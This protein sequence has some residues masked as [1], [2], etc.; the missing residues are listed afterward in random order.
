MLRLGAGATG[1]AAAWGP[2]LAVGLVVADAAAA[3]PGPPWALLAAFGLLAAAWRGAP[4]RVLVP[5]AG[6]LLL[7]AGARLHVHVEARDWVARSQRRIDDRLSRIEARQRA[8]VGEL[9]ALAGSIAAHP[10]AERALAGDEAALATVFRD[11]ETTREATAERPALALHAL[12]PLTTVAWAGR[13]GDPAVFEG[14]VGGGADVF[15][16]EGSVSTTLVATVPA[17]GAEGRPRGFATASLPVQ[18]RRNIGNQFLRDFDLLTASTGRVE[19]RYVDAREQGGAPPPFPPLDPALVAREGTLHAPDGAVLAAVRV[20]APSLPEVRR[21]VRARY[22]RIL[23]L[24]VALTL[25]LW[26]VEARREQATSLPR[27]AGVVSTL[28][29]VLLALGTPLLP[30]DSPLVSPDVYA[31]TALGPLLR[32]PLDLFLTAAWAAV[33]G[34]AVLE[35]ATRHPRRSSLAGF[36]VAAPVAVAL[37]GGVLV[38]L[39]DGVANSSLELEVVPLWPRSLPHL[40][41][42]AGLLVM[43]AAGLFL[44]AAAL[45]LAGPFPPSPVATAG[46]LGALA[47][48]MAG[49]ERLWPRG[50][51]D[52]PLLPALAL[53]LAA[54]GIAATAARWRGG[55]ER[56][57][58]GAHAALAAAAVTALALALYPSL[59]HFAEAFTRAQ[60]ETDHAPEVLR[61]PLWRDYVLTD[62]MRRIDSLRVL[63]EP[64]PG[65]R[66]AGVE[67]LAFAVWSATDLAAYGFS[68]AVEVQ[69]ASGTVISRFALNLPSITGGSDALPGSD[70]WE[71]SRETGRLASEQF[72]MLHARRALSYHGDLHGAIHLY[73]K[74]DF[75]NLPFVRAR[76]PYSVLF[77]TASR[78]AARERPVALVSYHDSREVAFTTVDRPPAL[79]PALAAGLRSGGRGRWTTLE[80]DNRWH[81]AYVFAGP[82]SIHV[83][84]YPLLTPS[85]YA[86]DLVEAAAGFA[87]LALLG[88]VLVVAVRSV[89]GRD[90]LSVRSL[91]ATVRHRFALRLFVAFILLAFVPVA[92][93]QVLVRNFLEDRLRRE[94]EAQALERA[95]IA[96]KGVEDYA[97]FQ[98]E[99]SSAGAPV[100]DEALVWLASVI[101]NDLDVF[102]RGRLLA[103]SKR[104]LYASGLLAPRVSGAV[105]RA[106]VLEREPSWLRAERIGDFSFTVASVPLRIEGS[107]SGVLSLPLALR[108]REV[109]AAVEDLDRSVRLAAVVFMVLAAALAQSVARRISGPISALTRATRRVAQGDLAARVEPTTQDELRR[110]VE[111]FNQMAHDL[112]R[113]RRDLERSNRLAAWAEMARQVAH[114][115]K[116]PLTPIQLSAEHLRR[117]YRDSSVDFGPTLEACTDAILKQVRALRE[118]VTEFSAFARPPAAVLETQDPAALLRELLRP[119]EAGLPPAVQ[120]RFEADAHVPRVL[121]DKRLLERAVLNLVENALQAVGEQGR[122]TIRLRRPDDGRLQIEVEDSGPGVVAEIRDRIFEPFFSTKTSGSGLGLALVK[123]I[124]EDHGGGVSLEDA[125]TGGTRAVL[126]LPLEARGDVA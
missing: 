36:A 52:L 66:P 121:A 93:L 62:T 3:A 64:P 37:V 100:S 41:M 18:V 38:L 22:D 98:R 79:D 87:L 50:W 73:V 65:P 103:S 112:D 123:R 5:A 35:A 125:P 76:D 106:V 83:L 34:V 114:E 15:V 109:Q 68:S 92:V 115:V 8:L 88:L 40:V 107:E 2:L 4:R 14:L 20:T 81:R 7:A 43:L 53:T 108:Q 111:S 54:G 97:F 104:E 12:R 74:E 49:A 48:L 13:I 67:E 42:Q 117:V 118:L 80:L 124:A 119:Y 31:S 63:E 113:Q 72:G 91:V 47:L 32:S 59:V 84:A 99:E 39:A 1:A 71:V 120:L 96:R 75:W 89:L 85:R 21:E 82:N 25:V 122:I 29:L 33:V 45:A 46:R 94:F 126:W 57:R 90:S 86:A 95:A 23:F 102:E 27:W 19:V 16:L 28:R 44:S 101:R 9:Q 110:L 30:Q 11:L 116:N 26:A 17:G 69:D 55:I 51:P 105:Y 61:Q 60:I 10:H 6:V 24:L 70:R 77:R 56:A 78:A 58:S